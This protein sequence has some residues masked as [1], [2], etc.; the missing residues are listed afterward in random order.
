MDLFE[1][2]A[3][4]WAELPLYKGTE[5]QITMPAGHRPSYR[6][7]KGLQAMTL[8]IP[9]NQSQICSSAPYISVGETWSVVTAG[10]TACSREKDLKVISYC[11]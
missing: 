11:L 6:D 4:K 3:G 5:A 8:S 7:G 10:V 1:F 2:V 9:H